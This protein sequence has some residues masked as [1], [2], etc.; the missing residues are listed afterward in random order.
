M[1]DV[2]LCLCKHL[3]LHCRI[4]RSRWNPT[5]SIV[6]KV[7]AH[8]LKN[9]YRRAVWDRMTH[10]LIELHGNMSESYVWVLNYYK[11]FSGLL[12]TSHN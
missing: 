12:G 2:I 8:V 6:D 3:H 7:D 1:Y 5:A 10:L 11:K 9:A 4:N